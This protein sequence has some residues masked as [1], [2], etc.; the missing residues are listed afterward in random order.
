MA[1][2][3]SFD[4]RGFESVTAVGRGGHDIAIL[5]D[6]SG[7][8]R[9]IDGAGWTRLV[10]NEFDHRLGDMEW[11]R[12]VSS[13]G[14][15]IAY[16]ND[17]A[18][19]DQ[20]W[21]S[22]DSVTFRAGQRLV[23]AERFGKVSIFAGSGGNDE[24]L[25]NDSTGQDLFNFKSGY[26]Q[27][28]DSIRALGF[29]TIAASS[30]SGD[31]TVCFEMTTG[32]DSLTREG[33]TLSRFRSSGCDYSA[34]GFA[35]VVAMWKPNSTAAAAPTAQTIHIVPDGPVHSDVQTI[36]PLVSANIAWRT[37]DQ[38][39]ER[40]SPALGSEHRWQQDLVDLTTRLTCQGP[41]DVDRPDFQPR[42]QGGKAVYVDSEADNGRAFLADT[43]LA[44]W[45]FSVFQSIR[46]AGIADIHS[47]AAGDEWL[48]VDSCLRD[49]ETAD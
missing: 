39:F 31:D 6:S 34:I 29:A 37:L 30:N 15:D 47:P 16:L 49:W 46:S 28:N 25:L 41:E 27:I 7:D 43:S 12:I 21:A 48:A 5:S 23:N 19:N 22:P 24:A 20:L 38:S 13:H 33:D 1:G 17:S 18:G 45:A 26:A 35:E 9:L 40:L 3:L 42:S 11:T 14:N 8:D 10:G 2:S 32:I 36:V 4:G 44:D